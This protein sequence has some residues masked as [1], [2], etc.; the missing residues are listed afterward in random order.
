VSDVLLT[1]RDGGAPEADFVL[2]CSRRKEGWEL[3][4]FVVTPEK[5]YRIGRPF[6]RRYPG[7]LRVLYPLSEVGGAEII[8]RSVAYDLPRLSEAYSEEEPA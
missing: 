4:V 3:G 8:R 2:V 7:G 6:D 1:G 5:W